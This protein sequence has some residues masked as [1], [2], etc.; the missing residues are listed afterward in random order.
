MLNAILID[1]ERNARILLRAMLQE[2]CPQ[3][4]VLAE[5]EDLPQGI[6]AIR[7]HQPQVVF[8]DIEMPVHSGLEIL[9]F[10]Q[11][12]EIP[13]DI[14]FTTAYQEYAI[15]A[16][17]MS[18]I[19]YLLKPIQA[20]ELIQAVQKTEKKVVQNASYLQLKEH[21]KEQS[22]KLILNQTKGIELLDTADILFLKGDGAYTEIFKKDGSKIVASKNL[23]H[24]EELLEDQ[25]RF[26]RVQK[27]YILNIHSV[28]S[29]KKNE[30]TL[31]AMI[32]QHA[33]PIS[34]DKVSLF[35]ERYS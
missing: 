26:M 5:C 17:K 30:G 4:K 15:R 19:D 6:E 16:F 24:F 21:Q 9:D 12:E 2:H 25:S 28:Q 1:D 35:L 33:I 3:V 20:T 29:V 14:I 34:P 27:S 32:H 22:K 11:P 8:L 31:L 18:A 10:F 13:F 23:K 7:L